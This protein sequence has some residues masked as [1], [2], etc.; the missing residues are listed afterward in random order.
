[1]NIKTISLAVAMS[2]GFMSAASAE[3]TVVATHSA[4]KSGMQRV[5]V[6]F[7]SNGDITAF[8]FLMKLPRDARNIDTSKCLSGLKGSF[9]G[10]CVAHAKKGLVAVVVY[11]TDHTSLS[12]GMHDIGTITYTSNLNEKP[13]LDKMA[14]GSAS[15]RRDTPIANEVVGLDEPAAR[16]VLEA[17]K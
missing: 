7:Q 12:A 16:R 14:V 9:T 5:G 15:G 17:T 10:Q 2:V 11:S 13:A 8:Q 6:D 3:T 1:M 4:E